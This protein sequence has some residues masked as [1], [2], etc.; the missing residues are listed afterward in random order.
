M[1]RR[2]RTHSQAT[3]TQPTAATPAATTRAASGT[4][5]TE[6]MI[7]RPQEASAK[8]AV[9]GSAYGMRQ[10]ARGRFSRGVHS[11]AAKLRPTILGGMHK[12]DRLAGDIF[13]AG[14][15]RRAL[16]VENS[17]APDATA[18]QSSADKTATARTVVGAV[19]S[20][21]GKLVPGGGAITG[22][23]KAAL[24]GREAGQH[25]AASSAFSEASTSVSGGGLA[26][27]VTGYGLGSRAEEQSAQAELK[28]IDVVGDLAG[29]ATSLLPGPASTLGSAVVGGATHVAGRG[30]TERKTEAEAAHALSARITGQAKTTR[31]EHASAAGDRL[32]AEMTA[33]FKK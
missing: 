33:K 25:Q 21:V 11:L 24:S 32:L 13:G 12:V 9:A 26:A 17:H 23:V 31:P 18:L 10:A 22:G 15:G 29:A 8:R 20:T 2:S 30:A 6:P 5:K 14:P 7:I 28:R 1:S 27:T 4:V 16:A 3:A 19:G